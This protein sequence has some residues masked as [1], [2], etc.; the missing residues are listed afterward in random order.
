M[1]KNDLGEIRR[2]QIITTYGPGSVVDLVIGKTSKQVSV[3][4]SGIDQWDTDAPKS[5]FD[6][7]EPQLITED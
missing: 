3:I 4:M 1:A 5:S 6:G 2:G 7:D